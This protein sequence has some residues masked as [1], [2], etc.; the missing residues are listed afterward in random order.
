M[1]YRLTADGLS[2]Q[3][4]LESQIDEARSLPGVLAGNPAGAATSIAGLGIMVLLMD[5]MWP[6][7]RQYST[8][9]TSGAG[10]ISGVNDSGIAHLNWDAFN[11]ASD[12]LDSSFDS[13][14]SGGFS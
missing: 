3:Q 14:D 12:A 5:D 8:A 2:E 13:F 6:E 1:R 7:F 10:S 11:D 4:Q 9:D